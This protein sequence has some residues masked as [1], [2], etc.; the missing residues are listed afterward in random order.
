MFWIFTR[1]LQIATARPQLFTSVSNESL[2]GH[3]HRVNRSNKTR[4]KLTQNANCSLRNNVLVLF[5]LY[6]THAYAQPLAN[7]HVDVFMFSVKAS[8]INPAC[9]RSNNKTA[10]NRHSCWSASL[11]QETHEYDSHVY[12][13]PTHDSV[14]ITSVWSVHELLLHL[15]ATR[16]A[17]NSLSSHIN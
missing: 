5:W 10:E 8:F 3:L 14:A 15:K 4:T 16:C 9:Q 7:R 6:R 2:P 11:I 17:W 12:S 13:S 1:W